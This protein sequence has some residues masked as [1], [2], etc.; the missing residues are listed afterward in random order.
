[1][2]SS[3]KYTAK[4][5]IF[6]ILF[7]VSF[8]ILQS[9]PDFLAFKNIKPVLII[10]AVL[11]VPIVDDEFTSGMYGA[12]AGMLCDTTGSLAFGFN[13]MILLVFCVIAALLVK[14]F[15][16]SSLFVNLVFSTV[17]VFVSLSAQFIFSYAIWR[18][19]MLKQLYLERV[20]LPSIFTVLVT[21]LIYIIF[22]KIYNKLNLPGLG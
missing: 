13:A 22:K 12:F 8:F 11:T 20:V 19:D 2:R 16:H 10:P 1:M 7:I 14:T 6:F 18:L 9:T 3:K 21:P 17:C 5:H 15:L 4:K